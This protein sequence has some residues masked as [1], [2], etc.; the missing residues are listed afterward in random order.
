MPLEFSGPATRM[1]DEAIVDAAAKLG[2][3]V[4][5]VKAVIDVASS[6]GFLPDTRPKILFE[7][8]YFSRLTDRKHDGIAPDISSRT[9]GG[10]K[11]KAAEYRSPRTSDF[12]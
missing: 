8:H 7:R 6:G 2:C 1:T 12:A 3:E 10:Y 4:A 11:G 9:A 5:A